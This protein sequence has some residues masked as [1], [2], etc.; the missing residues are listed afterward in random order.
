MHIFSVEQS[1]V[2]GIFSTDC[3]VIFLGSDS[4]D[5]KVIDDAYV[6]WTSTNV[7]PPATIIIGQ[8][9]SM[10][11]F[12][13]SSS[14]DGYC[15]DLSRLYGAGRK[16]KLIAAGFKRDGSVT[17]ISSG[18]AVIT[19]FFYKSVNS[20]IDAQ[21]NELEVVIPAP[22]GTYFDKLSGR[23][24][25]HF[26]RA[27]ALLQSTS[28]IEMLALRLLGP[29]DKWF[30]EAVPTL[31]IARIY[32]DTMSLWPIAEKIRQFHINGEF[33]SIDY[34]I[35]SFRS[36]DGVKNWQ[37]AKIPAFVIISATTSGGLADIVRERLGSENADIWTVL[38]L[39][40]NVDSTANNPIGG[41]YVAQIPRMLV[42]S[43]TLNG[44]RA[45]FEPN[46]K[47]IPVG[48]ETISIVG[49]R[50]L[51][52]TAKPKRV[53]LVHSKLEQPIKAM[54]SW[55]ATSH[56]TIIG[57]AN[58]D[59]RSRWTISFDLDFLIASVLRPNGENGD[60]LLKTWLAELYQKS[61]V[62][63]IYPSP[64]GTSAPD[65]SKSSAHF[66]QVTRSV[67][68]EINPD[69]QVVVASS[70]DLARETNALPNLNGFSVVVTSP[71]IGNGFAFKQISAL[72]RLRQP[73]GARLFVA[74]AALPESAANF[75][76][77]RSDVSSAP[78][79]PHKYS[80]TNRFVFPIGRLDSVFGWDQER[81][82]LR[83][84]NDDLE[85]LEHEYAWL[86][87]RLERLDELGLLNES[88]VFLPSESGAALG[89]STGFFLWEKS[90]T[91]EG[92]NFAPAVLLTVAA[93][94][95]SARTT[96]SK[97]DDT[98]L[99]SGIFQH[100]LICP[101]SFTRFNDPVIQAA[102]LRSAYPSELNYGVSPEMSY[103][104]TRLL[105]KWLK[106]YKNTSGAAVPEFLLAIAI[107]KLKLTKNDMS[108]ILDYA[109]KN[110]DGWVKVLAN[111]A[112]TPLS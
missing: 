15:R 65:I 11:T 45:T 43:P 69:R 66:A 79:S 40:A 42:G 21:I 90:E 96:S 9:S 4:P 14:I 85:E 7:P 56:S 109:D 35:E 103:D 105:L 58:F 23:Y 68:L 94:L 75:A 54:L 57:R 44:L 17:E 104:I 20:F 88:N 107:G 112:R 12:W 67:L 26:I 49:E 110:C 86:V 100:A 62:A 48:A 2:D 92:E 101:D 24:S 39:A 108:L 102:I 32:L 34:Q 47:K 5:T 29:F 83:K 74:L 55:L 73:S 19:G 97:S 71:I 37:P 64:D 60:S 53:R 27:E 87:D 3:L 84:L 1:E 89:L 59:G 111:I 8:F 31:G 76:Q 93:F 70:D 30:S 98:S 52:H 46:L 22:V 28:C 50:F 80:L 10:K 77:L 6:N 38:S 95:Q 72:L 18:A 63:I 81:Q 25:S 13:D 78:T 82:V 36:Y 99:R 33:S 51:S 41:R 91:I 106:Y 61:P 16:N